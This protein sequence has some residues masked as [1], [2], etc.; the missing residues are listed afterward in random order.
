MRALP[1]GELTAALMNSLPPALRVLEFSPGNAFS[2]EV[3]AVGLPLT[4]ETLD[5]SSNVIRDEVAVALANVLPQ[6]LKVLKLRRKRGLLTKLGCSLSAAGIASLAAALPVAL[7]RLVLS[8][9]SIQDEGA[10][11]LVRHMPRQLKVLKLSGECG[12]LSYLEGFLSPA[13]I[14]SL[15]G[16]LPSTLEELDLSVNAI[17]EEGGVALA[18]GLPRRLR[19]LDINGK[20]SALPLWGSSLTRNL[21]LLPCHSN[22]SPLMRQMRVWVTK[23]A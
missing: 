20:S 23:A 21:V 4:L 10:V 5:L 1:S 19:R 2:P 3:F 11:A 22:V 16:R 17:G 14:A 7:E 18:A 6:Q 9:N 13:G 12:M 15:A 8:F